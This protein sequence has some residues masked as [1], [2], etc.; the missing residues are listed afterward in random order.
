MAALGFQRMFDNGADTKHAHAKSRHRGRTR[1]LEGGGGVGPVNR[2]KEEE[3]FLSLHEHHPSAGPHHASRSGGR[4]GE[5]PRR[6]GQQVEAMCALVR[7]KRNQVRDR[8]IL[9]AFRRPDH[10]PVRI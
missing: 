3:P 2:S 10:F 9:R 8:T 7:L 6:F 1:F 5:P 4:Q